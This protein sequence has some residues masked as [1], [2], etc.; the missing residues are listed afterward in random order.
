MIQNGLLVIDAD[1]YY[2]I[3]NGSLYEVEPFDHLAPGYYDTELNPVSEAEALAKY[4]PNQPRDPKGKPTGGQ[5]VGPNAHEREAMEMGRRGPV[6]EGKNVIAWHGTHAEVLE[7]ILKEGIKS[8][9]SHNFGE[10]TLDERRGTVFVST[11]FESALNWAYEAISGGEGVATSVAELVSGWIQ[12]GKPP[13]KTNDLSKAIVLE[14]RIPKT[15]FLRNFQPDEMSTLEDY[16]GPDIKPSWIHAVWKNGP[17][18]KGQDA[19]TVNP[20]K[21]VRKADY[22][23]AYVALVCQEG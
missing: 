21:L 20:K 16:H 3:Y 4:S 17:K 15:Q 9:V 14:L 13:P 22:V 1:T 23:T 18:V 8:K 12:F 5:W 19:W 11:S 7:N 2:A 10:S 6:V